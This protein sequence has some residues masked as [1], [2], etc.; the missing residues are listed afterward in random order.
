MLPVQTAVGV[1]LKVHSWRHGNSCCSR[2]VVLKATDSCLSQHIKRTT[3]S[4]RS[5]STQN[6][7]AQLFK[8]KNATKCF[9]KCKVKRSVLCL[10]TF[11]ALKSSRDVMTA[12]AVSLLRIYSNGR[13]SW[14][15]C[16]TSGHSLLPVCRVSKIVYEIKPHTAAK[17]HDQ[18]ACV[19]MF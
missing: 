10:I 12:A 1:L 16:V 6:A 11:I 9:S 19:F 4:K 17:R 3:P 13:F 7:R 18:D 2:V 5:V 8:C 14:A 15:S